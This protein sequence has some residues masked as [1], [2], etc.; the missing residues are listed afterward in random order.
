MKQADVNSLEQ[1]LAAAYLE[2]RHYR[3]ACA[4]VGET[5]GHGW[6]ETTKELRQQLAQVI[7]ERDA[8]ET[9]NENYRLKLHASESVIARL[10]EELVE[11]DKANVALRSKLDHH[12]ISDVSLGW[13]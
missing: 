5:D 2:V 1:E 4:S 13:G 12:N 3:E 11:A 8:A 10:S 6:A 9:R 7:V